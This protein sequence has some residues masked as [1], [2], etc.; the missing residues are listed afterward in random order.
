ML[1][2]MRPR[3]LSRRQS[4]TCCRRPSHTWERKP[5]HNIQYSG[6]HLEFQTTP[7]P[8]MPWC[9]S[10][11]MISGLKKI[12]C[13]NVLIN[14]GHLVID[15]LIADLALLFCD[16]VIQGF[17]DL[18]WKTVQSWHSPLLPHIHYSNDHTIT[19]II[20]RNNIGTCSC[21]VLHCSS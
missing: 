5:Y 2:N 15:C 14:H 7:W 1:P 9:L 18:R 19:I 10:D 6:D 13:S 11:P 17:A 12:E 3:R 8:T 4:R 20:I 21:S 16:C